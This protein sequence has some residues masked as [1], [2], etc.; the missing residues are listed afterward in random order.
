MR[1]YTPLLPIGVWTN[2]AGTRLQSPFQ[3]LCAVVDAFGISS[4]V[5]REMPLE[6]SPIAPALLRGRCGVGLAVPHIA[7]F[8][9]AL[10]NEALGDL[11]I[12]LTMDFPQP[13]GVQDGNLNGI[14]ALFND[15]AIA[16][17]LLYYET[18]VGWAAS[19]GALVTINSNSVWR[20]ARVVRNAISHAGRISIDDKGFVPVSWANVTLGQIDNGREIIGVDL[21]LPDLMLLMLD[22]DVTLES[23]GN[24]QKASTL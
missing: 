10:L 22:M 18:Y 9:R 4:A 3:S 24:L 6:L 1:S 19:V 20:F 16:Q 12:K 14:K 23:Y 13:A 17:F 21:E 15:A 11:A 7:T 2:L 8:R 5:I